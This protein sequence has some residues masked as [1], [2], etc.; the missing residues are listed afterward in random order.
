[1]GVFII[2]L[3]DIKGAVYLPTDTGYTYGGIYNI[4]Q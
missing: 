2:S 3:S 1:M 4:P